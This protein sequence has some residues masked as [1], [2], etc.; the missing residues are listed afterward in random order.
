MNSSLKLKLF[1]ILDKGFYD[2]NSWIPALVTFLIL[3]FVLFI[4]KC[5]GDG[6]DPVYNDNGVC[7]AN[8]PDNGTDKD[9]FIADDNNGQEN[10]PVDGKDGKDGNTD[11]AEVEV[12]K[13]PDPDNLPAECVPKEAKEAKC[14]DY[15]DG[16]HF[17]CSGGF[18]DNQPCTTDSFCQ[19]VPKDQW[20]PCV[21]WQFCGY[22]GKWKCGG[23][24]MDLQMKGS[25][26]DGSACILSD[27]GPITL[28]GIPGQNPQY[29]KDG[30]I[31]EKLYFDDQGILI[32]EH[33]G[34]IDPCSSI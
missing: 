12:Y 24:L 3:L 1:K 11:Q 33:Y 27:E 14:F 34:I 2:T 6:N 30:E 29:P 8:C 32:R 26:E 9:G 7:V 16:V 10:P 19:Q 17:F 15:G 4:L 28:F 5:G 31:K 18:H 25:T 20:P 22:A 23:Y 13:C 21:C